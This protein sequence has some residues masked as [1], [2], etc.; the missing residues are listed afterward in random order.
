MDADVRDQVLA[1]LMGAPRTIPQ[2]WYAWR[3]EIFEPENALL[4]RAWLDRTCAVGLDLDTLPGDKLETI[5]AAARELSLPS[6]RL[7][8]VYQP[9][10]R[11]CLGKTP[12]EITDA[13]MAAEL[14]YWDQYMRLWKTTLMAVVDRYPDVRLK[15]RLRC[16]ID[17]EFLYA[18]DAAQGIPTASAA[19]KAAWDARLSTLWARAEKLWVNTFFDGHSWYGFGDWKRAG[20]RW[21]PCSYFPLSFVNSGWHGYISPVL[22]HGGNVAECKARLKVVTDN[23]AANKITFPLAPIVTFSGAFAPDGKF[24]YTVDWDTAADT[25]LG[26]YIAKLP[27][28]KQ[29]GFQIWPGLLHPKTDPVKFAKHYRAFCQGA[30][31]T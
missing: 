17:V 24:D 19:E 14:A 20:K 5:F 26:A 18:A 25:E 9:Y 27:Q 29:E 11:Y 21:L 10:T 8:F 23:M 6:L 22:Y 15:L 12:L 7:S 2:A 13:D 28:N 4:F 3:S 31:L 1:H 16:L 30:K